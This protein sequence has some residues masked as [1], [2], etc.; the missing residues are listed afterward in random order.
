MIVAGAVLSTVVKHFGGD[1]AILAA[2]GWQDV[3]QFPRQIFDKRKKEEDLV[4]SIVH[5]PIAALVELEVWLEE[6]VYEFN[7]HFTDLFA[8]LQENLASGEISFSTPLAPINKENELCDYDVPDFGIDIFDYEPPAKKYALKDVSPNNPTYPWLSQADFTTSLLFSSP[9]LPFSDAQKKV[10]L[11]WAKQLGAKNVPS[12]NATKK[13]QLFIEDLVGRPTEKVTARS[14]NIFYINN[15]VN[16]IA[17]DYTNPLTRFAMQDYPEDC[18]KGILQVFNDTKMLL[19][20]PSPPAA[21]V[22]GMIYFVNELLQES[23]GAY[24]I[25]ER[26]FLGSPVV[27]G[28]VEGP[29]NKILYVLGHTAQW[30]D[31]GFIIND[32]QE[33]IPTL[34]FAR[35]YEDISSMNELNCGL[36]A[37]SAKY[38]SLEP[39]PLREKAQGEMVYTVPLIIF[40]DNVSSNISKQWNKHH[41][42]YM[43]NANLPCEMLEKEFFVQFVTLS[44]HAAPMELMQAMKDS[45]CNAA[46]SGIVA[47]DCKNEEEVMLI[48]CRLFLAGDNP[49]QAEECSHA[50]LNCN[51]FCRMC[52]IGGT[53]EYKAFEEGY[54]SIFKSGSLRTPKKTTDNI[55][56][57]FEAAMKSGATTKVQST[58]LNDAMNLLFGM[59]GINIHLDTPTEILHTVLLGVVKYFGGQSMFILEKAKLL[60][61][62]QSCLKSVDKDRLNTPSLNADYISQDIVK[63]VA[64]GGYWYDRDV[65]RWVRGGEQVLCCLNEHREQAHLLGISSILCEPPLPGELGDMRQQHLHQEQIQTIQ[66]KPVVDHQPTLTPYFFLKAYSIHNCDLIWLVIPE[67]LRES[68]LRVANLA[69]VRTLAI[70]QMK[71]KKAAKKSE[72]VTAVEESVCNATVPLPAFDRAPTKKIATKPRKNTSG[73]STRGRRKTASSNVGQ[74]IAGTS[75]QMSPSSQQGLTVPSHQFMPPPLQ[76]SHYPLPLPIGPLLHAP[77]NPQAPLPPSISQPPLAT[78]QPHAST[79][80]FMQAELPGL[81]PCAAHAQMYPNHQQQAWMAQAHVQAIHTC[82]QSQAQHPHYFM[83]Y[84]MYPR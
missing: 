78:H 46:Q 48:L 69:E 51:Y 43:S 26:F 19:D 80:H 53:K 82:T 9:R 32:E 72:G 74:P 60:H 44:P 61:I 15:I 31:A 3:I 40:M 14:G 59:N 47:W 7:E 28:G 20:L 50:G 42:I 16:T 49:M 71:D 25:P 5:D 12:P 64:T 76:A 84:S 54:N 62:F 13:C 77:H 17:K 56:H 6:N 57:Q 83:D 58:M 2:F 35:S 68:P 70:Q 38:G 10:V 4:A 45:L 75:R 18:G 63:H 34:T 11:N 33:I 52:N 24:F 27:E 73:T 65:K 36:T 55:Q 23:S 81:Q 30:T 29:D 67:A 41:T 8:E 1:D 21:R 39:N 22:D 66:T 37:L 79:T